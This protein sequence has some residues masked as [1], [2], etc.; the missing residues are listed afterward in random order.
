MLKFLMSLFTLC[1]T[2]AQRDPNL[3]AGKS[4]VSTTMLNCHGYGLLKL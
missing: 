2:K 4:D 3:R 1:T